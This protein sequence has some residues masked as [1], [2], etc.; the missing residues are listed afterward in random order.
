MKRKIQMDMSN[1]LFEF[2]LSKKNTFTSVVAY[3]L[4]HTH[5]SL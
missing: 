2:S 5:F 3:P 4:K 1:L